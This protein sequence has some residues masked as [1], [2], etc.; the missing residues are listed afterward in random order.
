MS[1]FFD[2]DESIDRV[3]I[4]DSPGVAAERGL[5][6][7]GAGLHP[8]HRSPEV[9]PVQVDARAWRLLTHLEWHRAAS[10]NTSVASNAPWERC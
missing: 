1:K 6:I 10:T 4:A 5:H 8:L 3:A 2:G 7:V 9:G